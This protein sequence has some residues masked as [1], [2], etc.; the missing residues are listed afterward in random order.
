MVSLQRPASRDYQTMKN[1]FAFREPITRGEARYIRKKEDIVT[2][3]TGR[4]SAGFDGFVERCLTRLDCWLKACGSNMIQRI[5][6]TREL[7]NKTGDEKD[8]K[9]ISYFAPARIDALVNFIITVIIF[10]LLVLPVV[11]MYR[12]TETSAAQSPLD[13][14]GVL[15]VFTCVFGMA[16][17]S[18]TTAKRHELFAAS[19]A[20]AAV[21]VFIG[22]FGVQQVEFLNQPK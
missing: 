16:M 6:L 5:F 20:Y 13:A 17:S 4:E 19:A 8:K 2:L 15:I 14:I 3:R 18:L 12:I 1:W 22:N 7:Q 11:V 21:V 10:I 9:Y